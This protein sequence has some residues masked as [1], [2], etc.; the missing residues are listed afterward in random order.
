MVSIRRLAPFLLALSVLLPA[1]V[2]ADEGWRELLERFMSHRADRGATRAR[3]ARWG[4]DVGPTYELDS[5]ARHVT[6]GER[7]DCPTDELVRYRGT[8]LRYGGGSI[9]VHRALVPRLEA[10][11]EIVREVAIETYGREPR[12]ILHSGTY[13]CRRSRGRSTRISEHALGNALDLKGLEFGPLPRDAELPEGVHRRL[14]W[15]FSVSVGQHWDP[16][17]ERDAIHAEFLHRLVDTLAQRTDVFRGIVGPPRPRHHD[18][19]HLDVAP[20][21]YHLYQHD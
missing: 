18:H 11:E 19:I 5:V 14:R 9:R 16:R 1:G 8:H 7:V 17:R 12:R 15:R 6:P 20:W 3:S 10:F 13:A 2:R 4:W 21:R